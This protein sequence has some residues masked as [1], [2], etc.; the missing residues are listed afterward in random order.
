MK[1]LLSLPENLVSVFHDITKHSTEEW[2]VASDPAGTKIGSGGGTAHLLAEHFR[3]QTQPSIEDYLGIEKKIIIHAGG[4]SRRLPAYAPAGKVLSPIPVFRWSRGQ[5][6]DQTL[7]DL[8]TPLL[9]K[10]MEASNENQNTLIASGDVMILADDLPFELPK[11]DVV[12]LGIWVDQHLA[13]RHGVFFTPRH[14]PQLLDFMLQKPSHQEIEELTGSHLFMM[15]IGVWIL[16]DRAI[17][18]LMKKSG[19]TDNKFSKE[20][21]DFYD[22]Y[23]SFGTC[24]GD[25]PKQ[26]DDEINELSVAILPLEKGEFYHFG[27]SR[28]LITSTEKIQN[29]VQDQRN[30]WHNKVKAHPSL[31]V[32]NALTEISWNSN[33]KN[34]W[35]ENSHIPSGWCLHHNHVLTGIPENNWNLDIPAGICIDIVPVGDDLICIRPY[36]IDDAFRGDLS[37]DSTLWMGQPFN[38]WLKDRGIL[39][40][41]VDFGNTSDLQAAN[42]FPLIKPE[43]LNQ[44]LIN[45]LINSSNDETAKALWLNSER[46]SADQ[47]S[48]RAN[49]ARA[50][51]QRKQF[52]KINLTFLANNYSRSVFYQ[53][54]LKKTAKEFAQNNLEI[55][56]PIPETV[57]PMIRFRDYMFRS[58]VNKNKGQDGTVEEQKAF[59]LLQNI[60]SESS[61]HKVVPQLNIYSDQIIWGRSPARLDLAGGWADTP[62]FCMQYGGSVMNLAVELNEQPPIQ[63]Y[64]RLS[65]EKKITL[66][67]IDNGVSEVITSYE[68]LANYNKVGSAFSIPKAA[69]CLAG[70]HP[71]FCGLQFSSLEQQL[72]E[73]GGGFEISMLAA[74][75]KGS[76]LGTSSILA[77]T[78]LGTLA[79]FASLSWDHQT[80]CHRTLILEQL[81]TT[82]GGWQDQYGG[83]LPGV[84]LLESEPGTQEKMNV[85]W[86]PDQV[87]TGTD[88][89][90]NWLLYYTGIT[91]VAKNVLQDI[92]S[93][94]FLNEG[95]R[96][97]TLQEIKQ[98][99]YRTADAIQ[100]YD[101]EA[102]GKMVRH[103]WKL[104]QMLDSGVN[105]AE[106][107]KIVDQIDDLALGHKLL[108]AGGGGFMVICAKDPEAAARIK[109]TLTNNPIN[110]RARFVKMDISQ[111]G[112]RISR[113]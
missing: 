49:L 8:Q 69:L 45:W 2:F 85:R 113:S 17:E 4:Q 99:A 59:S 20:I 15:D 100:R 32:Q 62:P 80:I 61:E 108:G 1:Y 74:I 11:A 23:S 64:I 42:I 111:S 94:M 14:N 34:I 70:F 41:D 98:H 28:E 97:R 65:S 91:R 3:T 95:Q 86:L 33:H 101:F 26:N 53:A 71:D 44:D 90:E 67:S 103:S 96:L 66:R 82:G 37:D 25:H 56:A 30:I 52:R 105:T 72:N 60:I 83:I 21:P 87:F 35:I 77:A 84:K 78:L 110:D 29:R 76:G 39:F 75:P 12:C 92:V 51:Q 106:V 81:L 10:L 73:F 19:W 27:T 68:E 112:F 63:A 31:F 55:P 48:A 54:D 16:S 107:Q 46:I 89:K 57:S 88:Y 102:T 7:L 5:S 9:D 38:S 24:L 47:I 93:G 36:G 43:N 13:S 50:N 22:L 18:L 58:E 6:L 109:N 40:D 104:N 79:D